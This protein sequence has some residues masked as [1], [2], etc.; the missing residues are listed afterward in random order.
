LVWGDAGGDSLSG[1]A[2]ND[3]MGGGYGNDTIAGGLGHDLISG[4]AGRDSLVGGSGNDT[5]LGGDGDDT[6]SG[7]TGND[8]LDGGSGYDNYVWYVGDGNDTVIGS[9]AADIDCLSIDAPPGEPPVTVAELIAGLKFDDASSTSAMFTTHVDSE[10]RYA[11][12]YDG[13][14]FTDGTYITLESG[15]LT[16]RGQTI[17]F[18]NLTGIYLTGSSKIR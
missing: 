18:T 11:V 3:E 1:G 12:D 9:T 17:H 10:T 5:L 2:G 16:I 4:D 14:A 15:T 6:L 13:L 7:G 8:Y